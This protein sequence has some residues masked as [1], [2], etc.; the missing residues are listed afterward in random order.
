LA[1]VLF[2]VENKGVSFVYSKVLHKQL[3]G[4]N[5]KKCVD[6]IGIENISMSRN[7]KYTFAESSTFLKTYY[8]LVEIK[9]RPGKQS[10]LGVGQGGKR[11]QWYK[12][13]YKAPKSSAP[14]DVGE[15]IRCKSY[16]SG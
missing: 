4:G 14:Q 16:L 6:V 12:T 2:F 15:K 9:I 3:P 10:L 13:A 5:K 11:R 8:F 7:K 1:L